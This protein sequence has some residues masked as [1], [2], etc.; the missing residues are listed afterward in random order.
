M[1][2]PCAKVRIIC[3]ITTRD[4]LLFTGENDC[5][6]PQRHCPREPGEDYTKCKAICEQTGH[7]ETEAIRKANEAG[8]D[9]Q[10]ARAV[11][12]GHY[13]VCKECARALRAAGV[14]IIKIFVAQKG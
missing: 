1:R 5:G 13:H 14:S 4:N 3:Q 7:A 10:G 2:G 8:A 6:N 9:L 12:L 11:L